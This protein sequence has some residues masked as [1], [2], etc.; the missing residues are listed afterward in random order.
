MRLVFIVATHDQE[1]LLLAHLD[2]LHFC[3]VPHEVLVLYSGG[4]S[5]PLPYVR[6]P[7]T[8]NGWTG[9]AVA[10][11]TGLQEARDLGY[12]VAC[13][14]NGDDWLL[15]QA[16]I[17]GWLAELKQVAG[18]NWF[19]AG[20]T[21]NVALNELYV[22]LDKYTHADFGQ[23]AERLLKSEPD[24]ERYG[25]EM[26]GLKESNF[27]HLPGREEHQGV[28]KAHDGD[29]DWRGPIPPDNNRWFNRAWRLIGAHNHA[30]RREL[31]QSVRGEVD[32]AAELEKRPHFRAWLEG[33][34]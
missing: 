9:A 30:R 32:Y 8:T 10:L 18:Y 22:R 15:N 4:N 26:L 28:G 21:G 33:A 20:L 16:L 23:W 29:A 14:R 31:Y 25:A 6:Y 1:A 13:Y 34:T 7:R 2:I 17:P 27:Y 11:A 24:P 3:P 5:L 12:D 19:G